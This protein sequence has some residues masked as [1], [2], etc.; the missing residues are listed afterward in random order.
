MVKGHISECWM[1]GLTNP[2][3]VILIHSHL[4]Y[5]KYIEWGILEHPWRTSLNNSYCDPEGTS[6]EKL[7]NNPWFYYLSF[8]KL[9]EL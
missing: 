1:N 4:L 7:S 6:G 5:W 2:Q 8:M 3:V 9:N